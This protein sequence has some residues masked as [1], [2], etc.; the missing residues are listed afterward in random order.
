MSS[1]NL[2]RL[3]TIAAILLLAGVPALAAPC[4]NTG[5]PADMDNCFILR[6]AK[7]Q[8]QAVANGHGLTK[9]KDVAASDPDVILVQGPANLLPETTLANL[10]A[11]PDVLEVEP[12]TL[13]ALAETSGDAVLGSVG[14]GTIDSLYVPGVYTGTESAY[15][16]GDLWNGYMA[17]PA[18][19][20]IQL[21]QLRDLTEAESFGTGVVAIIDT[22]VDPDH[23]ALQGALVP[24]YDFLLGQPGI[25]SEWEA[26]DPATRD[27]IKA[28]LT[29]S[30]DQ[31]Y[32]TVIEG[33][34]TTIDEASS[35]QIIADQSY[36]T[37]I[38][39]QTLPSGFGHGTMVAGIVRLVAPNAQIMPIRV[40]NGDGVASL[41]DIIEAI[42]WAVD[43]GAD[44]INMSFSVGAT[45]RALERAIFAAKKAKVVLVTSAGN[46]ATEA[47]T[48]PAAYGE[49]I[50]VGSTNLQDEASAFTNTGPHVLLAA[51]GEGIVTLFPGNLYAGGWGTSFSSAFVAGTVALLHKITNGGLATI[52]R[53]K[54]ETA[55]EDSADALA[56]TTTKQVGVGRLDSEGAYH[57]GRNEPD[58]D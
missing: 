37:V 55:T 21:P 20:L 16:T 57:V 26:L 10:E 28:D 13:E 6:A 47:L 19:D 4:E 17:Q 50:G 58:I 56:V 39:T 18:V 9:K 14:L 34:A 3:T 33:G 48:Y 38:E 24:G 8:H 35:T 31:S 11:D 32:S 23:I 25:A 46:S 44:V 49:V 52:N 7:T 51:P 29:A 40:F 2:P 30:G 12:A 22:G 1:P 5:D 27:Q 15:F 54:T 41:A 45:S 43:N 42:Y 36:S 53:A